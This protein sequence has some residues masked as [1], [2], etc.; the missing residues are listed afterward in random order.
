M[1]SL[2]AQVPVGD[3]ERATADVVFAVRSVQTGRLAESGSGTMELPTEPSPG[4]TTGIGYYRA[5]MQLPPGIYMMRV[6][7]REPGGLL[8]SADR[9]FQVR[10]LGGPGVQV[11]DLIV[12]SS[13]VQGLPVRAA[14]YST[15][16]ISGV[17]EAYARTASQLEGLRVLVELLPFG[18]TTAV[19]SGSADLDP[20]K[21]GPAGASRGARVAIPVRG[22]PEGEY[23][24][25]ATVRTGSETVAELVREVTIKPGSPPAPPRAPDATGPALRSFDPSAVLGGEVVSRYVDEIERRAS[26]A[27]LQ[28]A[29]ALARARKWAEIASAVPAG[30]TSSEARALTGMS[31]F[32]RREFAA[33]ASEWRACTEASAGDARAAFLLGWAL[34]AGGDD[35]A[36]VSA[37]QA[38]FAA[39]PSFVP[40]YLAAIEAYLRL[41][42][43][44]LA[45][46]VARSGLAALPEAVELRNRVER[47]GKK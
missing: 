7:V 34:A 29:L 21:S 9:R 23:V 6:V 45:L 30:V 5:Q 28:K 35:R 17:F 2:A 37:W 22:I 13:E 12:G 44:E 1:L 16:A 10:S 15:D 8:G 11:G 4:S 33:A 38:A 47:L 36:A 26:G 19:T 43:P 14:V 39:D 40:A 31:L 42:Q 41:G 32:A 46:Q 25:R 3:A 24:V 27:A 20:I 18:T